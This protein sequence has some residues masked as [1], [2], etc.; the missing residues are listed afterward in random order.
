MAEPPTDR[1]GSNVSDLLVAWGQGDASARD[2]LIPLVYDELYRIAR[3]QMRQE[4]ADHTLQASALV[5]EAYLRL[6]AQAGRGWEH[7]SQFFAIAARIMRR[8]LVDHARR[9]RY[10]KRGAGAM[11]VALDDMDIVGEGGGEALMALD[12][13][14]QRLETHDG[15]KCA[16][17]E[18]RY[19]GGLS[20][21][22]TA[23]ALNLSLATVNRDW[24]FARAWLRQQ[25]TDTTEHDTRSP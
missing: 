24:A 15:R 13:A 11:R 12:A 3:R 2:R 16:V 4:R 5:N 22:E 17:V 18:L 23:K 8:V 21:E 19:F 9:R 7:R 20:N 14:L 25:L 6:V 1:A 10:Q